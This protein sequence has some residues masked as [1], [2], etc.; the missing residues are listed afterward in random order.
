MT[1]AQAVTPGPA[2]PPQFNAL[3]PTARVV[4]LQ[5]GGNDIGFTDIIRSC[6]SPT[7]FGHP[8]QDRFVADG[9]DELAD[10]VA[11]AAPKVAAVLQGIHARSPQARVL[12]VNDAAILPDTG[13]G[14]WPIVPITPA[15]VSY[16]RG[17]AKSLNAM[18]ADRA[19]ANGAVA[20][21][22][23]TASIGHDACGSA[24]TKW[25]EPLVPT[26]A[27]A[28]FH[29]NARGEAGIAAVVA[30]AVAG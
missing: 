18:L 25:V 24:A 28:P 16:L 1:A 17:V 3:T 21:D 22:D 29:P 15:D 27:A 11:A 30:A 10:R 26:S 20:V 19:A 2:N 4:T 23:Y 9:H 6:A 12:V 14:C 8:C 13:R 5:I 7:P